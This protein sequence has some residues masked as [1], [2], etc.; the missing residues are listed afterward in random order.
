MTMQTAIPTAV[1][2]R[3]VRDYEAAA[4]TLRQTYEII[5]KARPTH[6]PRI[7]AVMDDL[8][9]TVLRAKETMSRSARDAYVAVKNS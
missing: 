8:A 7:S 5:A 9:K 4:E 2:M 6:N 3:E 1:L